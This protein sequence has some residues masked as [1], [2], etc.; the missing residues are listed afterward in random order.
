MTSTYIQHL[1]GRKPSSPPVVAYLN[2]LSSAIKLSAAPT[3]EIKSYPDVIY[4]NFHTLGLS[5]LFKPIEGYKPKIGSLRSELTEDKMIL[6]SLDLYNILQIPMSDSKK[7]KES[8]FSTYPASPVVLTI[9]E[10]DN[11]PHS[12]QFT[13]ESTG[14]D[15]VR[16]FGEPDRKG[17]GSG[18]SS[19]S[20]GIWCEWMKYGILVEFGG[21]EAIGPQA[22]ERG[23][24]AV[25]KVVTIFLQN[26][27]E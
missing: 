27:Q 2:E 15:F 25:W 16:I 13:R 7:K 24:D 12:L 20:I 10:E 22:W 26:A 1:L 6:E 17:G 4:Y 3:P 8:A 14:K 9:G 19:G 21:V 5:L 18:P 11:S 23:K